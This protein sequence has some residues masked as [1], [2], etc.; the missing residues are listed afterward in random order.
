M[1]ETHPDAL[2]IDQRVAH[3]SRLIERGQWMPGKHHRKL[4]M[5]WGLSVQTVSHYVSMAMRCIRLARDG[6]LQEEVDQRLMAILE[7]RRLASKRI[8]HVVIGEH[9]Y[10]YPDPDTKSMLAADRLYLEAIGALVRM[11]PA[12]EAADGADTDLVSLLRLEL[13]ANPT[14]LVTALRALRERAPGEFKELVE[15]TVEAT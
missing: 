4:A 5:R 12:G 3:I 13:K 10:E 11:R 7:D 9:H 8:K 6:K 1:P 14:M 2:V 15:T